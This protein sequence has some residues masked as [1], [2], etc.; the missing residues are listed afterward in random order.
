[1]GPLANGEVT[2]LDFFTAVGLPGSAVL[3]IKART[4]T[5]LGQGS[6]P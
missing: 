2:A 5:L 6:L 3:Q 4:G 1:M